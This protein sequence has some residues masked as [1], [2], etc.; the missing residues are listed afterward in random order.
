MNERMNG[1]SQREM[2][3]RVQLPI[4]KTR[5]IALNRRIDGIARLAEHSRRLSRRELIA[6]VF[7]AL[8]PINP[9][10]CPG[11]IEGNRPA[12]GTR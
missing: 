12:N 10:E 2:P 3:D 6:R 7:Y 11:R 4:R 5:W 8:S 9:E 1:L